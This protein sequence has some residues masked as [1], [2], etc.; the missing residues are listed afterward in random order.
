MATEQKQQSIFESLK[1]KHAP[2]WARATAHPFVAETCADALPMAKFRAYFAQDWLFVE[3]L[4]VALRVL[5]PRA[6]AAGEEA[7]T[8][9]LAEAVY[10]VAGGRRRG[11]GGMF[12]A[13]FAEHGLAC[14]DFVPNPVTF[15][16]GNFVV[17]TA[18]Q[19]SLVEACFCLLALET[20]Y[21]EWATAVTPKTL[22][23]KP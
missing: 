6:A 18:L 22:N 3:E 14:A 8:A 4:R 7:L 10:L 23:S 19:G 2:M 15:G 20:L 11:A 13:F 16:F 17:R 5:A 12:R 21:L 9:K 1:A